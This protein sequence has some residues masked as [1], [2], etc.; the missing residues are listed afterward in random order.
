MIRDL[1]ITRRSGSGEWT[2]TYLGCVLLFDDEP[3]RSRYGEV[4]LL[5]KVAAE[6]GTAAGYGASVALRPNAP[7]ARPTAAVGLP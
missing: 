1:P 7:S 4:E 2:G 5:K 6:V 3:R